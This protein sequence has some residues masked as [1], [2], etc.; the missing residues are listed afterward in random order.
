MHDS[1]ASWEQPTHPVQMGTTLFGNIEKVYLI[2][3]SFGVE[4]YICSSF[5]G[6]TF[7]TQTTT[8]MHIRKYLICQCF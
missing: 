3:L 1:Q 4:H 2:E 7:K 6:D 8:Y 5:L